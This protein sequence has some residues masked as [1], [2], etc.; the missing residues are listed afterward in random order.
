[1]VPADEAK[2]AFKIHYGHFQF[3]VM[4]FGLTNAPTIFQCL[5]NAIF[6]A[7]MRKF[8]LIFMDDILVFSKTLEEHIEHLKLV[9]QT[10]LD[11]QLFLKFSKCLFAQQQISYLG[12]IISKDGMATEQCSSG[13]LLKISLNS[14]YS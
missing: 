12:H 5:M 3:R 6:G 9:F 4:P 2:T 1:M 8:V 14:E 10:L 11:H 7:Y 13:Q